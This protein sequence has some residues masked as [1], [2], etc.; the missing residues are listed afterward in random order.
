MTSSASNILKSKVLSLLRGGELNPYRIS[1]IEAKIGF[2][3]NLNEAD[4]AWAKHVWGNR[5]QY[6]QSA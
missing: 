6:R 4:M 1:E 2:S 3:L 5:Q